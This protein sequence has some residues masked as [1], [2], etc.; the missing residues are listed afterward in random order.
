MSKSTNTRQIRLERHSPSYWRVTS[1]LPPLNIFGP[2]ETRRMEGIIK[3]LDSDDRVEVVVFDSEVERVFLTHYD[4]L[5]KLEKSTALPAGPTGLQ[6]L[7]D[8][9]ARLKSCSCGPSPSDFNFR[10]TN[11]RVLVD[12]QTLAF[13][14]STWKQGGRRG[15]ASQALHQWQARSLAAMDGR[16]PSSIPRQ[17]SRR[18]WCRS[19][20]PRMSRM[21]SLRQQRLRRDGRRRRPCGEPGY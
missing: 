12:V 16:R 8:M 6:S 10:T 21:P 2:Q 7:P 15:H 3:S 1:D 17:A 5:A 13:I 14:S 20:T 11:P 9:L 4:F 19:R 18:G